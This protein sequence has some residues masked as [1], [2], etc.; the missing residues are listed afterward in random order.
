MVIYFFLNIK[1][2]KEHLETRKKKKLAS[3]SYVI[4]N[5]LIDSFIPHLCQVHTNKV[6]TFQDFIMC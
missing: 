4:T 6:A 1:E 5:A 3:K 2:L